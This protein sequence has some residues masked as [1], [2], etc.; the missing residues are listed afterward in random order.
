[1][2]LEKS[3]DGVEWY[4]WGEGL[5][6]RVIP[7]SD[8]NIHVTVTLDFIEQWLSLCMYEFTLRYEENCGV[9]LSLDI[10]SNLKGF[11]FDQEDKVFF[12]SEVKRFMEEWD[13]QDGNDG[14]ALDKDQWYSL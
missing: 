14:Q 13:F 3:E 11:V 7:M 5:R 12:M 10:L 8:S 1:M 9:V 4:D 6:F 2:K